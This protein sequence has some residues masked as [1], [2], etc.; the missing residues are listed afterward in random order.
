[1]SSLRPISDLFWNK[2]IHNGVSRVRANEILGSSVAPRKTLR[3]KYLCF[4]IVAPFPVDLKLC[5]LQSEQP[6][7]RVGSIN[8]LI[9]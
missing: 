7:L 2:R 5:G 9:A 6:K 8:N 4:E 1:M 3:M